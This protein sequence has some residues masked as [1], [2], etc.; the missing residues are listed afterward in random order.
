MAT[1]VKMH[2]IYSLSSNGNIFPVYDKPADNAKISRRVASKKILIKGG[3]NVT[4]KRSQGK[5]PKF[6]VTEVSDED[7]KLLEQSKEFQRKLKNGW[8]LIDMEPT[9]FKR[10][11]SAQMESK[12]AKAMLKKAIP[13]PEIA[14]VTVGEEADSN[15]GTK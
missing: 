2:K 15:G 9:V 5:R 14:E 12:A 4:V 13:D 3:A 1:T 6:V 8:F 11:G 7:L 10:D